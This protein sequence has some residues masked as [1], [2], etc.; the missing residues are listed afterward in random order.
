[1][2]IYASILHAH[3]AS[4]LQNLRQNAPIHDRHTGAYPA[5]LLSS[6]I[7]TAQA[8]NSTMSAPLPPSGPFSRSECVS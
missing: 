4:C 3:S 6:P 7:I 1:M 5:L 8:P 2:Y